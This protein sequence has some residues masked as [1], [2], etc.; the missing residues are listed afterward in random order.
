MTAKISYYLVSDLIYKCDFELNKSSD[1]GDLIFT[2]QNSDIT[3]TLYHDLS[4]I[5]IKSSNTVD[6]Y[7]ELVKTVVSR[8]EVEVTLI[9]NTSSS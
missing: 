6:K 7:V 4:R 2:S 5:V 8:Y 3:I 9:N 1:Q